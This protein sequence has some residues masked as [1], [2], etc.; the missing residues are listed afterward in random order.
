MYI[1][2]MPSCASMQYATVE[3]QGGNL[4]GGRL[5]P[6]D[7]T[8]RSASIGLS[9]LRPWQ[10]AVSACPKARCSMAVGY[11][12]R[13]FMFAGETGEICVIRRDQSDKG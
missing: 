5:R 9:F 1:V 10:Q 2:Q 4:L 13:C 12:A 8:P 3:M 11:L 7:M 6:V